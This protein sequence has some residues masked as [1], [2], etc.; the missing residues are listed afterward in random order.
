MS[1]GFCRGP[2]AK[3]AHFVALMSA[4]LFGGDLVVVSL[5]ADLVLSHLPWVG[6]FCILD[7]RGLAIMITAQGNYL[8]YVVRILRSHHGRERED[9]EDTH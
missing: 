4:L 7:S 2:A 6:F 3:L 1:A 8:R 9:A 5:G